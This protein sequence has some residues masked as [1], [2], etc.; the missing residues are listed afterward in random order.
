VSRTGTPHVGLADVGVLRTA[1]I[2]YEQMYRRVGGIT[3]RNRV[4]GYLNTEVAPLL[5]G[6]YSDS[7]GRE[8]F[9]AV[10]GLV[11]IAGIS[12]YDSDADGLAQRYFHQALRLAKASGD[13]AFGGYVI[14]LLVNQSIFLKEYR[15]AVAFAEAALR[16]AGPHISPG[17]A[18]DLYAM[19]AK[20][21]ARMGD[22]GAARRCM[23]LAETSA[24]R[25]RRDHEP[26]ETGYV[27]AGFVEAQLAEALMSLGDVHPAQE[28]ASEAV[29][30]RAHSRGR[31]HRLAT[32][33][34]AQMRNGDVERAAATAVE[35][36]EQIRGMESQRL[37]DRLVS[38]RRTL[39]T[40][41]GT[42]T[43]DAVE[44]IDETLRMP[45]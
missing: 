15:R 26:A 7:T 32:L 17:L 10:G 3:T 38:L 6:S 11:A 24:G 19:Q 36:V 39:V 37:R 31:V 27:Q 5:R 40:H 30:V 12:T 2:H 35:A 34:S 16:T 33:T 28:Y 4:V 1:R 9:R 45:L 44:L 21:H 8:L 41:G 29:R 20:A 25:I 23:L 14:A 22:R 13:R 43:A 18:A 42:A